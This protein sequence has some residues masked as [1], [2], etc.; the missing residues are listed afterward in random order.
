MSIEPNVYQGQ[1]FCGAVEIAV[2]GEPVAAGYCHCDSCR[3]WSAGPVN[4]FT[5]WQPGAVRIT[6]GAD[7]VDVF[8]KSELSYRKFCKRCGGHLFTLHPPWNLIDIYAAIIKD[9]KFEPKVHVN[10]GT[11]VLPMKDGLPKFNDLPKDMGG[12]GTILAE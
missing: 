3:H 9:F 11:T 4:A 10:Y 2:T 1:C 7:Q 5:L 6:K 8:N 12:S